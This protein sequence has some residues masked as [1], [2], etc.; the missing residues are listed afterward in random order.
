MAPRSIVTE[1]SAAVAKF[2]DCA[3]GEFPVVGAHE[4]TSMPMLQTFF[5][6]EYQSGIGL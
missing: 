1:L 5:A 4:L 6:F 3:C 2:F